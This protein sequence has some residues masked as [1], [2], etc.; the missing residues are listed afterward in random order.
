M[1]ATRGTVQGFQKDGRPQQS[2]LP[3]ALGHG[4]VE[5]TANTWRTFSDVYIRADGSGEF[6][7][8]R[9]VPGGKREVLHS[10]TWDAE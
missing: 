2:T 9:I 6:T 7:L 10:F 5:A 4:S 1:A 3:S 8:R